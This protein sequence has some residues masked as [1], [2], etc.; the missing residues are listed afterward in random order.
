MCLE[1]NTLHH[2]AGGRQ[3]VLG[4]VS[5][6]LLHLVIVDGDARYLCL[7]MACN[8]AQWP[9]DSTSKKHMHRPPQNTKQT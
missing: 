8:V 5:V 7:A 1:P 6:G 4:D 2:L 9:T 3:L